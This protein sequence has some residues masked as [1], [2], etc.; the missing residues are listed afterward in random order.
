LDFA[1][2]TLNAIDATDPRV[3]VAGQ[4]AT[5]HGDQDAFVAVFPTNAPP[6]SLVNGLLAMSPVTTTSDATPAVNAPAGTFTVT[7]TFTNI[8]SLS[9]ASPYFRV[10][11]LSGSDLLLNADGG[12]GAVGAR[13]S[14]EPGPDGVLAPGESMTVEFI[15]GLQTWQAFRFFV[16]VLGVLR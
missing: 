5:S 2:L 4:G 1:P 8:S 7:A 3:Y 13:I 10:T 9:I 6:V 11:E 12:P 15:I 16:D 14:G